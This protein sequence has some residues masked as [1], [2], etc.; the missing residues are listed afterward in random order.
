[1][2]KL[3]IALPQGLPIQVSHVFNLLINFRIEPFSV[4]CN[5]T[6][7]SLCLSQPIASPPVHD[8]FPPDR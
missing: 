5:E 3:E 7:R 1:M 6:F 2:S 4:Y 8:A